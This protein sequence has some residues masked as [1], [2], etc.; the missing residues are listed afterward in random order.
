MSTPASAYPPPVDVGH[1]AR[2]RRGCGC[3]GCFGTGCLIILLILV[4]AAGIG[5]ALVFRVP[6]KLGI[7]PS[8][9]TLLVDA[10]DRAG[11]AAITDELRAAGMD[12]TG[13]TLYVLPV[14][15][16][17]G[18]LAYAIVDISAGFTFPE[19]AVEGRNPIPDLITRIAEGPAAT[20]AGVAAV[21]LEY[22]DLTGGTV[23]TLV[24]DKQSIADFAAGRIDEA[25]FSKALHGTFNPL[26][27]LDA[28]SKGEAR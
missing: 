2:H 12:T 28:L 5:G 23:G 6:A 14:A 10:P 18:T 16:Q 1:P 19:V 26:S 11:A 4:L 17:P 8:G 25:A 9:E 3:G 15:G 20:E 22:R 13:L 24:A 7:W 27:A 21:A